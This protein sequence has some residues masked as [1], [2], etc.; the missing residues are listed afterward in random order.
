MLSPAM[1]DGALLQTF[2]HA[3]R[4]GAMVLQ[5]LIA[6]LLIRHHAR[7]LAARL[8]AAFALGVAA[9]AVCSWPGFAAH[10]VIWFAPILA[11]CIGNSLVFW[12]FARALFDDDFA[13]RW[14]HAAAWI[15]LAT[16]GLLEVLLLIPGGFSLAG[17]VG[18]ALSLSSLAFAALAV[19]QTLLGWRADLIEGRRLL[20]VFVVGGTAGYIAIIGT[21]ELALRGGPPPAIASAANA[22][23]LV[24]MAS[25]IAWLL[26]R[27]AGDGLFPE[28]R[29]G[30]AKAAGAAP[31]IGDVLQDAGR[32]A[33]D[34]KALHS[35]ERVMTSERIYRQEGLTIG[36]LAVKLGL[37]EYK[38]RQLINQGLGYRNF[39][40]YLNHYRIEEA[41]AALADAAQAEVPV[42]T[43]AMDAGFQSLNP[44]NRAFKAATGLTP[45]EYRR[46]KLGRAAS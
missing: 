24:A 18:I 34:P 46:S 7:S 6:T 20:R 37:P 3:L 21:V 4:G 1:A 2:D 29:A 41:K 44:F 43:I 42:L 10:A 9:Y 40:T 45:T 16:V 5:L 17:V 38:L 25:V 31:V 26:F 22:A 8:G 35:L 19:G 27:V 28:P 23:G 15:A 14:W 32:E 39:N 30:S 11:I 12:L 36:V 33:P 13:Y